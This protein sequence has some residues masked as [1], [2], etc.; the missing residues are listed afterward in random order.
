[1]SNKISRW[2]GPALVAA[3][4]VFFFALSSAEAQ[5]KYSQKGFV[6]LD[7][8]VGQNTSKFDRNFRKKES[9]DFGTQRFRL[10][11]IWRLGEFA[12][13]QWMFEGDSVF[14]VAGKFASPSVN[15]PRGD[16]VKIESG[17]L[18]LDVTVPGTDW[19][20]RGGQQKFT[21]VLPD[22][23]ERQPSF[24]IYK[25]GGWIRP[26]LYFLPRQ[27]TFGGGITNTQRND[28]HIP[29]FWVDIR[30]MKGLFIQPHFF[31]EN[32]NNQTKD[33]NGASAGKNDQQF[34]RVGFASEYKAKSW[35]TNFLV[36]VNVGEQDS[37]VAGVKDRDII[38]FA[39]EFG[40]GYRWGI[41]TLIFSYIH[42]SGQ[43]PRN[44]GDLTGWTPIVSFFANKNKQSQLITT[45]FQHPAFDLE[46]G[47]QSGPNINRFAGWNIWGFRWE[48][49]LSKKLK[50][51][52]MYSHV[53]SDRLI[54]ND[55]DLKGES[56]YLGEAFD[57]VAN[58]KVTKGLT[59]NGG[60]A[61]MIPGSGLDAPNGVGGSADT[62]C[63]IWTFFTSAILRF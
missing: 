48:R 10:W 20:I 37:D 4:A 12:E 16:A 18:F 43:T 58:Y 5:I 24:K 25:A 40:F 2:I 33:V 17:V 29:G 22:I 63:C 35:Y 54:D 49:P 13:A 45:T 28:D 56:R 9:T 46:I 57:I 7:Y 59:F 60:W 41:N 42:R 32:R 14:G 23:Q 1:M 51:N 61:W 44:T 6:L 62:P 52:L 36:G 50:L 11:N 39:T 26:T 21:V 27:K 47:N 53:R 8:K 30:P 31:W 55:G 38:A 15:P 19:H 3:W 34:A